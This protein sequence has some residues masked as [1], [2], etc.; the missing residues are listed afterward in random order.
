L[1][2]RAKR[3]DARFSENDFS[4][5]FFR[6]VEKCAHYFRNNNKTHVNNNINNEKTTLIT[7]TQHKQQEQQRRRIVETNVFSHDHAGTYLGRE[8]HLRYVESP[9]GRFLERD[10]RVALADGG[11]GA[12]QA[13][14][15][16]DGRG[17]R[18]RL[19]VPPGGRRRLV[20]HLQR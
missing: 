15:A 13:E 17:P 1:C 11:P 16:R 4:F 9:S 18:R 19:I 20:V 8:R 12:G 7:E 3:R 2:V 10:G 5:F 6:P 14:H